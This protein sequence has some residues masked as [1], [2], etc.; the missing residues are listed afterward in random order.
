MDVVAHR[1]VWKKRI[2][3]RL[4]GFKMVAVSRKNDFWSYLEIVGKAKTDNRTGHQDPCQVDLLQA[5]ST[6]GVSL[7]PGSGVKTGCRETVARFRSFSII[8]RRL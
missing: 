3:N 4:M 5:Q 8:E 6:V 2:A 1:A 7:F